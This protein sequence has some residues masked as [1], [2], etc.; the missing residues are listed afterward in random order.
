M[1]KLFTIFIAMVAFSAVFA[2]DRSNERGRTG[3]HDKD[4]A[5]QDN[6]AWQGNRYETNKAYSN[7]ERYRQQDRDR[8]E[9]GRSGSRYDNRGYD[10]HQYDYEHERQLNYDRDNRRVYE[11]VTV[12]QQRGPSLGKAVVAGAIVGLIAGAIF[13]H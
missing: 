10:Q 2:Q 12:H 8:H 13:S 9:M 3:N 11:K 1:K 4:I 5:V 7:N 6:T